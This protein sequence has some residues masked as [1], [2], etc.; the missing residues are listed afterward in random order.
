MRVAILTV[1]DSCSR[2]EAEDKSGPLLASLATGLG[3]Q[4]IATECCPDDQTAIRRHLVSWADSGRADLILTTGGTGFAERDVTPEATT[5]VLEKQAPGLVTA[6]LTG[7]LK[8]TPLAA[9]S[10]PAAGVRGKTIIVNMP[11]SSKAVKECFSFLAPA[12]PHAV[13]LLN[14]KKAEVVAT[15]KAL[16]GEDSRPAAAAK[17]HVCPHATA[18]KGESGGVGVAGRARVSQWPMISVDQAQKMVLDQCSSMMRE[19][20]GVRVLA[21]EI[22]NFRNAL[23]R[24]LCQEVT[25]KDPLPPFPASIKDGYAVIASDGAG[26]RQVRGEASAGASPDMAPL[27]PGEVIRINTGAPVP[28]GADAVVMVEETKLVEATEEGE[29]VKV[30]ILTKKVEVGQDIRPVGSDIREGE[31]VLGRGALMGPGE[32]GLLAAVGVTEVQVAVAPKV[33]VLSTGNELQEPGESLKPGHIRDSNKTTLITLLQSKGFEAKDAGVAKD[34]IQQ[35]TAVLKSALETSDLLVTTGGVSMGD[36]DL[37]RQVLVDQFGAEIHFARVAMKPGK[38]TTLASLNLNG[39]K[40]LV[41]GL[42]GNPVSATVTC[43]LYVLPALRKLSGQRSPLPGKVRAKLA[44]NQP[45]SLDPRPEYARVQL[46]FTPGS[47][48]A[49]A[50]PTGNQI[51]SRLASMADANGLLLLPPRDEGMSEAAPGLECDA[52]LIGEIGI[53]P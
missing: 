19:E 53:E 28:P 23:G 3:G 52:I 4:V 35:L 50:I 2:G 46:S 21:T 27:V 15:H 42:P 30:E 9:L 32:V 44:S 36:R 43:H 18:P 48:V 51:S 45:L 11:G 14:E 49:S 31:V 20:M 22:V 1:S 34:D 33:A 41:L 38:P 10:R 47:A 39:K 8:V 7:S 40:R 16:Q 12:L 13:A 6:M 5:A 24:V 29:E 26:V 37:L 17:P 25:A